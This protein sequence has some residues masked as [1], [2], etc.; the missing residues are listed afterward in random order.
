MISVPFGG[1]A[2]V[3]VCGGLYTV[4]GVYSEYTRYTRTHTDLQLSVLGHTLVLESLELLAFHVEFFLLLP[5]ELLQVLSIL[6]QALQLVLLL[7]T[8]PVD[9]LSFRGLLTQ[10]SRKTKSEANVT[11]TPIKNIEKSKKQN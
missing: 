11:V 1:C 10:R 8:K 6:H 5:L 9:L 3:Q 4:V 7:L 2:Q